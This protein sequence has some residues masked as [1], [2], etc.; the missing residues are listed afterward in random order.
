M[1]SLKGKTIL[2]TGSSR[3]IG[4]AIALRCA[5]DGANIII[6]G[7][8]EKEHAQLS[9]TIH[10]VAEEVNA[11]GGNALSIALDVRDE[12]KIQQ[13]VKQAADHFGGIDVLINNAGAI[14]LAPCEQ[15]P[16]KRF[17]LVMSVNVR[18]TFACAQACLPYLKQ[19]DNPHIL[20]MSPPINIKPKWFKDSVAYTISKYGM[21]CCT[22]GLAEEFRGDGI[23][24]NSLW[25]KTTIAT[26][27]IEVNFPKA[28]Y[29][30]SRKP[31]IMAD[32]AHHIITQP[33]KDLTGHFLLDEE[34]LRSSGVTDFDQYAINPGAPLFDDLYVE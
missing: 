4:R 25:P 7:K 17:D 32:A 16:M 1:Q 12:E 27:A 3:G 29:Q 5:R 6:T 26:A 8:T 15:T 11:A 20:T 22:L 18:A 19:S 13:A 9:G 14:F 21:S 33:S 10:S 24:V 31:E 2:I 23:A 30:A 28:V 34:V